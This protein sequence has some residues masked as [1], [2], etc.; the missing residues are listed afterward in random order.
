MSAA[1]A[2]VG[3][4]GAVYV[5]PVGTAAPASPTAAWGVGWVDVGLISDDGLSEGASQD[6]KEFYSWGSPFAP[7]RTQVTK[8][9]STF[10]LS[11]V[12]TTG[13]T[14]S[15][16]H[17]IPVANFAAT[18]AVGGA[19]PYV[20]FTKSSTGTTDIR[21]LGIDIIDDTSDRAERII[22]PR[23]QVTDRS[24]IKY[25]STEDVKLQVTFKTLLASDG[26]AWLRMITNVTAP[27]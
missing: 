9:E 18:A 24:D 12:E 15:I 8:E 1:N 26:T 19:D 4:R 5:A 3:Y 27:T 23:V 10:S 20:S 16:F 14:L 6:V 22:V 11:F 25:S 13:L 7:Y 2:R 17:S 21:S